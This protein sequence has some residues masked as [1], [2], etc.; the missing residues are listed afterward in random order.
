MAHLFL[1]DEWMSAAREIRSRYQD[2]TMNVPVGVR[3]NQII[4]GVPFGE[5]I[6]K[7]YT[8]TSS[9]VLDIDLGHLESADVT[10]TTDYATARNIFVEQDP[11]FT[12]QAFMSGKIKVEGDMLKMMALQGSM[13]Q[14][15]IAK[16]IAEEI[17]LIT[18]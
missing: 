2:E 5:G 16:K 15:E 14:N 13:P 10:V 1:S 18:K 12:M 17:K 11:N 6:V 4:T 9:G 8:D 3:M 7:T